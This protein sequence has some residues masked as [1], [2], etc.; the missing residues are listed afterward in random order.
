MTY[1]EFARNVFAVQHAILDS[2]EKSPLR[3][4]DGVPQDWEESQARMRGIAE[5]LM[6]C[7]NVEKTVAA[8]RRDE[9]ILQIAAWLTTELGDDVFL[10]VMQRAHAASPNVTADLPGSAFAGFL[11]EI[12][13]NW[14]IPPP[15]K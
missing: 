9:V 14:E 11:L 1:I 12:C 8:L 5:E 7:P 15:K 10:T 6:L 3:S 4:E 13:D 2:L